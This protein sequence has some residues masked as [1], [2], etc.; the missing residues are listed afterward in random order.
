MPTPWRRWPASFGARAARPTPMQQPSML[1]AAGAPLGALPAAAPARRR[2]DPG[3]VRR[4]RHA[5]LATIRRMI[6]RF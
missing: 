4:V 2:V 5:T 3:G 6:A 1:S